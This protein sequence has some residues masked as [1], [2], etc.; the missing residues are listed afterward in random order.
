[1]KRPLLAP[2]LFFI[3]GIIMADVTGV[4]AAANINA[5]I[6]ALLFCLVPALVLT[7]RRQ[8][9]FYFI[10]CLSF[11]FLGVFRYVSAMTPGEEDIGRLVGRDS[12]QAVLYGTV[13]GYPEFR[14]SKYA[15][16]RV[17]PLKVHRL[18]ADGQEHAVTGSVYVK[19]FSLR[20]RQKIG[21]QLVI[22]GEIAVPHGIRNPAGFDHGK[23][24]NRKGLGA[25]LYSRDKDH[26]LKTGVSQNPVLL[27][28]RFLFNIR[29]RADRVIKTC[30]TGVP[31]AVTRAVVLGLRSGITDNIGETFMKTG[32][33]HIL[34]V[35]GLHIGVVG[36]MLMGLLRFTRCPRRMSCYLT[37]IGICAFAVFAGSRPSS[38][39]AALMGTFVLASLA[40]ERKT[41]IVNALAL[42]AF[43]ITFFQPGQIFQAGFI[44]SYMAVLSIIYVTPLADSLFNVPAYRYGESRTAAFKRYL[45]KSLSVSLAVWVGMVPVIAC[46]FRIITPSVVIANLIAV[47]ILFLL[48]ILGFSLVFTGSFVMLAPLAGVIAACLEV[49]TRFFIRAM[50]L[51]SQAPFSYIRVPSPGVLIVVLYYLALVGLVVWSRRRREYR[52]LLL[53]FLLVAA[54]LFTWSRIPRGPD[55]SLRVTFFDV[56][57]ADAA[58]MEFPD[59]SVMLIDGGSGG[60]EAG[61]DCG[62]QVLAPYLWQKGIRYI[63]AILLTH[64]DEDHIGGLLYILRNFR[65]GT[66]IDGRDKGE[67]LTERPLYRE[68]RKIAADRGVDHKAVKRGDVIEG[69]PGVRFFVLNPPA[70]GSYGDANNDGV[71]VKAITDIGNSV[72]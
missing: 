55:N 69:M 66:V 48:V 3:F 39:R 37:I 47:P 53:V 41:D 5:V 40:A 44:L 36:F 1:M 8:R 61:H 18:S 7:F 14:R 59:G 49:L 32:T 50:D 57:K 54:N 68:F 28:Q 21:D 62:R 26:Y 63:D 20:K 17:F 67:E 22:G 42:S 45:L 29:D 15:G 4:P 38:M 9:I 65:V 52:K 2:A 56:N 70:R 10:L 51:L 6:A 24:L 58:L 25:V 16:Y 34:A 64:P 33:M 30:L 31:G 43:F 71:V 23:Y 27:S 19:L 72:F 13:T 12:R 46:Y 35:S 11:L 60:M